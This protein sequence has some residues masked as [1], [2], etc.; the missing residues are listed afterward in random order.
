MH[1]TPIEY[2]ET[3]LNGRFLRVSGG[4]QVFE[5]PGQYEAVRA[6]REIGAKPFNFVEEDGNYKEFS[7]DRK[8]SVTI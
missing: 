7:A 1:W 2:I 5:L 8:P 4:R 6:C 3:Q